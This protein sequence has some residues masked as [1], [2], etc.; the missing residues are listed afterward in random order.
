MLKLEGGIE[1]SRFIFFGG[2]S[3]LDYRE[4]TTRTQ[5]ENIPAPNTLYRYD[6]E[7]E[8][9]YHWGVFGGAE[10]H[11]TQHSVIYVE[12]MLNNRN[13]ITAAYEYRF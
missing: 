5:L 7:L 13:S 12:G 4:T 11:M 10:F 2:G 9:K 3:W 1:Y 6:D 8:E